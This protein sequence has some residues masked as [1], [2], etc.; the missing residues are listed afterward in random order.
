MATQLCVL[1]VIKAC[2][3]HVLVIHRKSQG[4]HQVQRAAGVGR[5]ADHVARIGRDFGLNEDDVKHGGYCALLRRVF[6]P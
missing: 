1:M 6:L 5:Q 3:S 4:L 2:T